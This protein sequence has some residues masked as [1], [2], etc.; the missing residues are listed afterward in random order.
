MSNKT[1]W[2]GF[3]EKANKKDLEEIDK[4]LYKLEEKVHGLETNLNTL[5]KTLEI[6]QENNMNRFRKIYY[7]LNQIS[8]EVLPK[9]E[10]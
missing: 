3:K 2:F 8:V 5:S 10:I 9:R 6:I 4:D 7:K 1:E